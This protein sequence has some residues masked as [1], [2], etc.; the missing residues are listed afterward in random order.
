MELWRCMSGLIVV[1]VCFCVC[2]YVYGQAETLIELLRQPRS[3]N[4][5]ARGSDMSV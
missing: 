1:C 3:S 5:G 4:G 2:V